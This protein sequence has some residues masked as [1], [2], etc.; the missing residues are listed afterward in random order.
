MLPQPGAAVRLLSAQANRTVLSTYSRVAFFTPYAARPRVRRRSTPCFCGPAG[1]FSL[2]EDIL[3]HKKTV[4]LTWE[5]L[6]FEGARRADHGMLRPTGTKTITTAEPVTVRMQDS[7]PKLTITRPDQP[8][9][10]YELAQEYTHVGRSANNEIALPYPSI[11]NR[12][13]ILIHSGPRH[14]PA[15]PEFLQRHLRQWRDHQRSHP[16]P[17]RQ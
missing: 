6:L 3:P 13:C 10:V 7:Q 5:Q 8:A 11:S 9:T 14:R 2:D 17:R 12:H 4:T 15:R 1:G 16:P